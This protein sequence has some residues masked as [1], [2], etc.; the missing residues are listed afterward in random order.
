MTQPMMDAAPNAVTKRSASSPWML[1]WHRFCQH[2]A[3]LISAVFVFLL[4]LLCFSAPLLADWFGHDP[5]EV[6]FM[7]RFEPVSDTHWLG[8]DELGR[9]VFLRLLY[10]GQVSLA[11]GAVAAFATAILGTLVGV[12]AGYF[13]GKLDA[14]LMRIADFTLSLPTLPLM[15]VLAAVDLSKLGLPES[16]A[17]GE[18]ASF[19][20]IIVIVALFGWP[21]TARLVRSGTLS[22][23]ERDYVKA[24]IG[25]GASPWRIIRRHVLPNVLSPVIIAT[26]MALGGVILLESALSFLGLGIQPPMPSWGNMLQNAQ[27]VIWQSPGLAIYPGVAILLTVMAFNFLGDALQDALDPKAGQ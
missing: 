7:T 13:G 21:T 3:G 8:A 6:D 11:V 9:D 1:V 27:E 18:N 23:R 2:K 26:T 5:F 25:Y 20:R 16:W 24:A 17:Q 4:T 10:G 19:I 15:I 12:F 22:V 14:V